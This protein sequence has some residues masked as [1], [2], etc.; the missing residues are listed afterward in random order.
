MFSKYFIK[1]WSLTLFSACTHLFIPILLTQKGEFKNVSASYSF[2][3]TPFR[4]VY[5]V[6]RAYLEGTVQVSQS[7]LNV[8]D[9]YKSQ[10]SEPA[11]TIRLYKE[12]QLKKVRGGVHKTDY[13]CFSVAVFVHH[14]SLHSYYFIYKTFSQHNSFWCAFL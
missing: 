5:A 11:K 12:Q 7:R 8:C 10:V 3:L 9:N 6:W 13:S 2:W 4:N 14:F 1:L